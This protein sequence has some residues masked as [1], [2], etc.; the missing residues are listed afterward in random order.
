MGISESNAYSPHTYHKP[1]VAIKPHPFDP[2]TISA[3]EWETLG[4]PSWLAKRIIHYRE[5]GGHFKQAGDVGRIY[6]FPSDLLSRLTPYM[7]FTKR[8]ENIPY[9]KADHADKP[10]YVPP[11]YPILNLNTADSAELEALPQLGPATARN[12]IKYRKLLG[13]FHDIR[14]LYELYNQDSARTA[15]FLPL[16]KS[17]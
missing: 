10:T 16:C 13:G 9:A 17:V 4:A 2:N 6:D 3:K 11:S 5:K 1:A 8:P 14:Q 7:C 15:I 12:I